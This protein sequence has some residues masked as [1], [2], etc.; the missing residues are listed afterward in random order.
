MLIGKHRSWMPIRSSACV[1]ND[2]VFVGGNDGHVYCFDIRNG[3]LRWKQRTQQP[4]ISSPP[5]SEG[6]GFVGSLDN[7]F[8]ALDSEGGW[9]AWRFPPNHYVNA[10]PRVLRARAFFGGVG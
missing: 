3:G 5:F 9:P 1:A 8:Y 2:S 6:L 4:G 10:S 7:N